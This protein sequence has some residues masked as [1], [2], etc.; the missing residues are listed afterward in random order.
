MNTK[1]YIDSGILE[2]YVLGATTEEENKELFALT[3]QYPEI[4]SALNEIELDIEYLAQQ[5]AVPPPPRAWEKIE[6][7]IQG[8]IHLPEV[9]IEPYQEK[10]T[11]NKN[12]RRPTDENQ[13]IEV[14]ATG[15]QMR[16]HKAWRWVFAA[17][18]I[19]GKIFL[20]FAIYFYLENRQAQE[21]I[22][23]LKQQIQ[24]FQKR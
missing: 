11:N 22:R 5:T 21:Q 24:Q 18:F 1:E 4:K 10:Q 20:G 12:K 23:D 8:L 3:K 19:L 2:A 15:N 6:D 17:V 13:F 14:E 16:I 9:E 7:N